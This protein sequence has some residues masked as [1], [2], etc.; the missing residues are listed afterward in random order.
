MK[1]L[2]REAVPEDIGTMTVLSRVTPRGGG[3]RTSPD[4]END[5][6]KNSHPCMGAF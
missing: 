6:L 3:D 1:I 4:V 2:N 5:T